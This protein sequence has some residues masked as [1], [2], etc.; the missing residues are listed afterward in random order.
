[1]SFSNFSF[2]QISKD[3]PVR[4]CGRIDETALTIGINIF[5]SRSGGFLRAFLAFNL[6]RCCARIRA[7]RSIYPTHLFRSDHTCM[8]THSGQS[9]QDLCVKLCC[10]LAADSLEEAVAAY[11]QLTMATAQRVY[12]S[13]A[14]QVLGRPIQSRLLV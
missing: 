12:R 5:V 9:L 4:V 2:H 3:E 7:Y 10:T 11:P 8:G 13:L 1:M 14:E 6:S